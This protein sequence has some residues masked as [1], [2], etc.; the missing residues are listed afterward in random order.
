M[1]IGSWKFYN[2]VNEGV[3]IAPDAAGGEQ[4]VALDDK[5]SFTH[6]GLG[7]VLALLG[8]GNRAI[9]ELEKSIDLNLSFA[10][11]YFGLGHTLFWCGRA[12]DGIPML[13]M[14]MRLSP[15]DPI[16]WIMQASRAACCN[17][18]GNYEE[19]V[20]WARKAANMRADQFWP[21]LSVADALVGQDRL[22]EA[23]A[24]IKAARRL[25]PDLSLSVIRRLLPHFH[26]DYLERWIEALR[27]AGLP[28]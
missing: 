16:L 17:N 24:A 8:Q 3:G 27:K 2:K 6:Y 5:D 21:H 7:M 25:K 26:T 13:D 20:E 1:S 4:A 14:A 18:L 19:A 12:A 9:A 10:H 22:D 11:G 15:H 28:E 23:R